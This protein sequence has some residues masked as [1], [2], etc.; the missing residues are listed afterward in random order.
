M[1]RIKAVENCD[2][3]SSADPRGFGRYV[4][5]D[6]R[7]SNPKTNPATTSWQRLAVGDFPF[8]QDG[9]TLG[10]VVFRGIHQKPARED[11]LPARR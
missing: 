1:S 11:F 10:F 5:V 7:H 4:G 6:F 3:T 2:D 9:M 8:R